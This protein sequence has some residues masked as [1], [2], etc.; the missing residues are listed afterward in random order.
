MPFG[1]VTFTPRWKEELLC[2]SSLGNLILEMPMGIPSEY[3][4]TQAAWLISA[5]DW[6]KPYWGELHVRLQ[7]WCTQQQLPLYLDTTAR[8]SEG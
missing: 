8:V 2:S 5:P 3:F 7:K 1:D 4:P 6:A